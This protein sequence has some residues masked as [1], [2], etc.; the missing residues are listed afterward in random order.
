MKKVENKI[1]YYRETVECLHQIFWPKSQR[2]VHFHNAKLEPN[3]RVT[4]DYV[5]LQEG[6]YGHRYKKS[7][8][9]WTDKI[10]MT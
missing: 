7:A 1:V 8:Y 3:Q 5:P 4:I 2:G 9:G 6:I 10:K